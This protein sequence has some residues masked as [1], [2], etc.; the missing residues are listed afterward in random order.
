MA[1]VIGDR[2]FC[3]VFPSNFPS[4][5]HRGVQQSTRVICVNT[6]S[7]FTPH[8]PQDFCPKRN[9]TIDASPYIVSVV[10]L[11]SFTR[12]RIRHDPIIRFNMISTRDTSPTDRVQRKT[13]Y[14]PSIF[15][16]YS[17]S[18]LHTI[19]ST[20]TFYSRVTILLQSFFPITMFVISLLRRVQGVKRKEIYRTPVI[21]VIRLIL[22][23]RT[24]SGQR[25]ALV[26]F[27]L[28][29]GTPATNGMV[30][31]ETIQCV[32]IKYGGTGTEFYGLTLTNS[33]RFS[34]IMILM[35]VRL[36]RGGHTKARAV[37]PLKIVNTTF[38]LTRV[39]TPLRG[40]FYIVMGP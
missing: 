35:L 14:Y 17:Q 5:V 15:M 10:T 12:V 6:I 9:L 23:I 20:R 25:G 30:I 29:W 28:G 7:I 13:I 22:I 24:T 21:F 34:I 39:L 32:T 3:N 27:T 33:G 18:L 2:L 1:R 31:R 40:L 37:T 38:C 11:I 4:R 8:S 36:I 19:P 16:I 26:Q